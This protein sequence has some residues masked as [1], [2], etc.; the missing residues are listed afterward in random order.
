VGTASLHQD[1]MAGAQNTGW[2]PQWRIVSTVSLNQ[3]EGQSAPTANGP[4]Y[5]WRRLRWKVGYC[6]ILGRVFVCILVS[7]SF[8]I[9]SLLPLSFAGWGCFRSQFC[10]LRITGGILGMTVRRRRMAEE[11]NPVLRTSWLGRSCGR[12][13]AP[14][15]TKPRN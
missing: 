10:M 1:E 8:L 12:K 2:I 6:G 11:E 4:E 14:T 9:P 13:T 7:L 3:D 5:E 15:S